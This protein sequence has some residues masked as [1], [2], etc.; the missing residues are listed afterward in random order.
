MEIAVVGA[1]IGGLTFALSAHRLGLNVKVYE[2][3]EQL[4][5][6]GVGINL[7]PNAVRELT[8]LGLGERLAEIAVAT[9]ELAY[10]S[11]HGQAIWS[12]PRGRAA[13]YTWPQYSIH[14]GR[15]QML[16]LES[17]RERLGAENVLTGCHFES[18]HESEDGL[19][20]HFV[21]RKKN[22][23]ATKA[24]ADVLVG[25]DGI[26][27]AVR[28]ALHRN[29]GAPK[30]GK[31]VMYRGATETKPF[32]TGRT[33][34]SAGTRDQRFVAYP[35]ST[36]VHEGG[37][38]LVNWVASLP[39]PTEGAPPPE[40]WNQRVDKD[41]LL[42]A[43]ARWRFPWLDVAGVIESTREVFLFPFVDREPLQ[44]WGRG[45]VTLL[46]DA[47]H[48][49]Y[50]IGS[51][52]GSQAVVDGRVLAA[53]LA[54]FKDPEEALQAYES[55]R[56]PAMNELAL[57]NRGLGAETILQL[58]EERAPNGFSRLEDVVG[59]EEL[60][61]IAIGFKQLAG[62]DVESVNSAPRYFGVA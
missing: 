37:P 11:K 58:V 62:I 22:G 24:T 2:S 5:P 45:R 55:F 6:L 9:A 36:P 21:D 41:R 27:S 53:A 40:E 23:I 39:L 25:A 31:W 28:A 59:R 30:Y 50:P 4:R 46:G 51:Q 12:E 3:V 57:K 52:A 26:H 35:M 47:A 8:A 1:G 13:G 34:I 48:P 42:Q 33:M 60:E 16:L 43:F 15:L 20:A 56:R 49:M 29:E 14:R 19:L 17:V 18:V 7:Q 61:S 44:S 10:F 54:A 38:V 32:L